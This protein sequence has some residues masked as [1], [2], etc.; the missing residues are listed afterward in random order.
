MATHSDPGSDQHDHLVLN[1]LRASNI[2]VPGH[3]A[4]DLLTPLIDTKAAIMEDGH[5]MCTS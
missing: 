1:H 2:P 5:S 4:D 3:G